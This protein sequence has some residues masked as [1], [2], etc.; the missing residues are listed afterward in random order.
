MKKQEWFISR[1][2]T[3]VHADWHNKILLCKTCTEVNSQNLHP[4]KCPMK[5]NFHSVLTY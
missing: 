3:A 1:E 4:P 5:I 2:N